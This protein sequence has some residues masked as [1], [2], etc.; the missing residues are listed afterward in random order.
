MFIDETLATQQTIANMYP[1]KRLMGISFYFRTLD[2]RSSPRDIPSSCF[3]LVI[4]AYMNLITTEVTVKGQD[5][6]VQPTVKQMGCF[7]TVT[8][9][10]VLD[11]RYKTDKKPTLLLNTWTRNLQKED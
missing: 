10:I 4:T 3:D 8:C 6:M 5:C 11:K 9:I 2:I 7:P 1:E